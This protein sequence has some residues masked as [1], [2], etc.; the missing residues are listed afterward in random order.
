[1][2]GGIIAGEPCSREGVSQ[3]RSN[4]AKASKL[5]TEALLA[6]VPRPASQTLH[7]ACL[8]R[9]ELLRAGCRPGERVRIRDGPRRKGRGVVLRRGVEAGAAGSP[10]QASVSLP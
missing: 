5:L 4:I 7:P 2:P 10:R 8:P 3:G 1:M 9:G 6:L